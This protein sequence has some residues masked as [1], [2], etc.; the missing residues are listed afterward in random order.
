MRVIVAEDDAK[1]RSHVVQALE[2][3]GHA[4][5]STGDGIEALWLLKEY[6]YD[7]AVL[8]ISLPGKDGVSITRSIRSS[9]KKTS[10]L[11]A[12]ARSD[13]QDR[14]AGLDAGADDYL[15]KPYSTE[16][17]LARLRALQRRL[18]PAQSDIIRIADLELD[19]RSRTVRRA[20]QEIALT[21]REFALLE[22]LALASP[23][24]VP[25]TVLIERVWDQFFDSGT[26]VLNVT[27]NHL[28]RKVEPIGSPPI[29]HT[30]RG[31]GYALRPPES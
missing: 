28:R 14:V 24:P 11:L 18:N 25:K 23:R 19:I 6:D 2:E 9:G 7:A 15:V 10:V 5:D 20:E 4:V 1:V 30:I 16:E 3:V 8:D 17:L 29:L 12:T 26:N 22:A 13:I 31:V 21:N 27:L